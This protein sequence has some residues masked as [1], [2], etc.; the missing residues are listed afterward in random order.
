LGRR[1]RRS[2]S[3]GATLLDFTNRR[4]AQKAKYSGELFI[5]AETAGPAGVRFLDFFQCD[6]KTGDSKGIVAL[7]L[8]GLP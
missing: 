8:G 6:K 4:A 1:G 7:D 5:A 2:G 3:L